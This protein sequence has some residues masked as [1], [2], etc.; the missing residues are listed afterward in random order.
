MKPVLTLLSRAVLLALTPFVAAHAEALPD[1]TRPPAVLTAPAPGTPEESGPVLQSVRLSP[2]RKTALISGQQ[3]PLGGRFGDAV[4]IRLSEGEAVLRKGDTLQT[5]KLFP[6][7]D[8]RPHSANTPPRS[9]GHPNTNTEVKR[10]E[11]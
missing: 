2:S 8:K 10:K 7:V 3:V 5:L 9:K 6:D 1:P 11:K 4:L